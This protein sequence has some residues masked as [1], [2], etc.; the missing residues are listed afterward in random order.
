MY[1][2]KEH[3]QYNVQL[4][5]YTFIY[6]FFLMHLSKIKEAKK[7]L[8]LSPAVDDVDDGPVEE[9]DTVLHP[10][11][12]HPHVPRQDAVHVTATSLS[13]SQDHP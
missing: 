5:W 8:F 1:F 7:Q 13:T 12:G 3:G 4:K 11:E 9:V 6:L 2:N 10:L